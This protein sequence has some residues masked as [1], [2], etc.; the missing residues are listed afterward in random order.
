MSNGQEA[1][2]LILASP[3]TSCVASGSSLN[4]SATHRHLLHLPHSVVRKFK[5][6][7]DVNNAILKNEKHLYCHLLSPSGLG[8]KTVS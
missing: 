5:G 1:W 4:L 7:T 6:C 3:P 8:V 2:I